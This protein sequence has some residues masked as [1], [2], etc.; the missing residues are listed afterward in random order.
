MPRKLRTSSPL[1]DAA[2]SGT[3][4]PR[5]STN[6]PA[7]STIVPHLSQAQQHSFQPSLSSSSPT[8]GIL[9]SPFAVDSPG[10]GPVAAP[11]SG[12]NGKHKS[13]M[14]SIVRAAVAQLRVSPESAS[15]LRA[16]AASL[17]SPRDG[18]CMRLHPR[19]RMRSCNCEHSR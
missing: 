5:R 14:S 17:G 15:T 6:P 19:K 1:K 3:L 9:T 18:E 4:Q 2:A 10:G 11:S 12:R 8:S 13:G 16:S 7:A